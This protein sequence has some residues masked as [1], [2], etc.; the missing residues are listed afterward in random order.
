[1]SHCIKC[2]FESVFRVSYTI[3]ITNSKL[4]VAYEQQ[5]NIC[6]FGRDYKVQIVSRLQGCIPHFLR[7]SFTLFILISFC[8]WQG[9][10]FCVSSNN[11]DTINV[12]IKRIYDRQ[13]IYTKISRNKMK[14]ILLL[15]TE[16]VHF[17]FENNFYQQKYRE[18]MGS[19]L[20]P[21]LAVIFMV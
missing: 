7:V 10:Y 1:M 13:E 14:E 6:Q 5:G 2:N 9:L 21:A 20:C 3:Q 12:V 19:P 4:T 18:I 8:H 11:D 16:N 17:T 15:C